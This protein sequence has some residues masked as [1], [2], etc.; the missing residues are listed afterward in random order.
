MK[1]LVKGVG[2]EPFC[3]VVFEGVETCVRNP[4]GMETESLMTMSLYKHY[5]A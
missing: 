3:H 5:E 1:S 4:S 2:C